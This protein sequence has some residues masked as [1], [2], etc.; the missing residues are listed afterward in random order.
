MQ[1]NFTNPNELNIEET[2]NVVASIG[3]KRSVLVQGHMG[4]GKSSILKILAERFPDHHPVYFDC[5]SKDLGDIMLPKIAQAGHDGTQDEYSK[6][7]P[8]EELGLHL[9]KPIILM[10]DEFGKANR[11]VQNALMLPI[12]ERKLAGY[13]M[14]PDS[15]VFLTT[16]KGGE[17]VGD[18]MADHH[19]NRIVIVQMSK[20]TQAEWEPWALM[21]DID[22]IMIQFTKQNPQVFQSY[23]EVEKYED[24]PYIFHPQAAHESFF[25]HR[26]AEAASDIL[27]LRDVVTR[28]E[29]SSMLAGTIGQAATNDLMA[30]IDLA[31]Q[32]PS[33]ESIKSSPQT[34]LVPMGQ[35]GEPNNAAI[36]MTVYKALQVI[37]R[38]W[39]DEWLDYMTRLPKEA[40]ALFVQ[41]VLNQKH[42]QRAKIVLNKKFTDWCLANNYLYS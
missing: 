35:N 16:N 2:A 1:V 18:L 4:S 42:P 12:L 32:L 5:T 3:N 10:I 40:Q 6:F 30:F 24:N 8:N 38:D 36:C 39:F 37:E 33:L 20:G 14:H 13:T 21:N 27:K 17:G 23:E 22:P 19:R 31:D 11:G 25:T 28:K 41:G 7:V 15:I 34:A 9:N 29:L 26:S